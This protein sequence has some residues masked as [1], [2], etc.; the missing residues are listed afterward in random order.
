MKKRK[1]EL[2]KLYR[3]ESEIVNAVDLYREY[4]GKAGKVAR[5][6]TLTDAQRLI[7]GKAV[8]LRRG[9]LRKKD[10]IGDEAARG[11]APEVISGIMVNYERAQGL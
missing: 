11:L 9:L 2:S 6:V 7:L 4:M 10:Y 5:H 1:R 8:R 3:Q